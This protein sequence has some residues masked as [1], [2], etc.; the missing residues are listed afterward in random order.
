MKQAFLDQNFLLSTDTA[1]ILYHQ[2]AKPMPIVDYH[3]H[4]S[5]A[6]IAQ[7]RQFQN[8]TQLWLEGDHYKWRLLRANGIPEEEITGT[9][10]TDYEKFCLWASVLPKAIG[11]PLYHW[12]HLEL[13][14][15]FGIYEPLN[16]SS[17]ER[18]WEISSKK[19]AAHALSA[20]N[21]IRHSNVR[22]L[23][24]TD[25]P[26]DSLQEHEQLAH[27]AAFSAKVFPA[28][29]PDKAMN[30]Q[31][32]EFNEYL[33]QLEQVCHTPASCFE[34]LCSALEERIE[35]FSLHGC[36]AAD[37]GLDRV[38]FEEA[39]AQTVEELFQKR[40]GG[41]DLTDTE[42]AQ[43]Q[44]ALLLFLGKQYAKYNI[45]MQLHYGAARNCNTFRYGLLGPDTGFDSIAPGFNGAGLAPLLNALE[46]ENSL[47]K[48]V[49]YSLNPND[50]EYILSVIGC[51][52]GT[53]AAGKLQH[54]CPWWFND[55]E[56]GI[57]KQLCDLANAGVLGNFIGMLTDSR[58]FLSYTRH[59]YFRRIL[60]DVI[61][62]WVEEGKYPDDLPYLGKMV[63]D[64]S[65]YNAMRYFGFEEP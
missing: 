64:I 35:Y 9:D 14:R 31:K 51:F 55:H 18:I 54:G 58:S 32:P 34:E 8:L 4:I 63:Q 56:A 1:K 27:D 40:R 24:T 38:V 59:E 3:C 19:C 47:P 65:Y 7:D 62:K 23:C 30:I 6:E 37:H 28:F 33:D 22:V 25:D 45:V 11:N 48:T 12:T 60:C 44:T 2:Y 15:Y 43:Y 10:A 29:R 41:A 16:E 17:A 20:R 13:Q 53:E 21:I 61:G 52:Q 49:V 50:N 5:P 39:D 46:Q 57:R 26:I 42:A 36:K